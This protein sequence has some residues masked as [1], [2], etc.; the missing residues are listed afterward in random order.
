MAATRFAVVTGANKGIG[1]EIVRKLANEGITVV[2]TARDE[3]RGLDA[4]SKLGKP[5]VVFHKLDVRDPASAQSLAQFVKSQF[6]RLDILVNNAGIPGV[7]VDQ[8]ALKALKVHPIDILYGRKEHKAVQENHE[9]AQDCFNTNYYGTKNVLEAL[10]P[11]LELSPYGARVVNVSSNLGGLSGLPNKQTRKEFSDTATLTEEKLDNII[12][13]FLDD[14]KQGKLEKN[15]WPEIT[16]AYKVSKMAVNGYTRILAKKY[17]KMLI[18]C[19]HPGYVD[20]DLNWHS[21]VLTAEQGAQAPVMLAMLPNGGP[22]GCYFHQK[23]V[24]DF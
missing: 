7:V 4:V 6:G 10:L 5:N 24:A 2:L 11:L 21:G 3:K 14:L 13:R 20:T 18:N 17:P 1:F 19:V 12:K 16:P 8:D 9:T 15:G 23:H 22:S